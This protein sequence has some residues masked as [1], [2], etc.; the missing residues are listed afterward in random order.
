M[1]SKY[2]AMTATKATVQQ[3][4]EQLQRQQNQFYVHCC[5]KFAAATALFALMHENMIDRLIQLKMRLI[6]HYNAK[7]DTTA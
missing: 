5:S 3:Q 1:L 7:I 6:Q 2:H 4:R